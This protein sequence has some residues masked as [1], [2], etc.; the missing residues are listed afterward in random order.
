[1]IRQHCRTAHH[2]TFRLGG[3]AAFSSAPVDPFPFVVGKGGQKGE[4]ALADFAGQLA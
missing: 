2:H 3:L 1:M 4:D